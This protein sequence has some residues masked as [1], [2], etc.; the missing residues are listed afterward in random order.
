MGEEFSI[1]EARA[2]LENILGMEL[3]QSDAKL[4]S[5]IIRLLQDLKCDD[6]PTL[7][8]F[9]EFAPDCWRQ[10]FVESGKQILVVDDS[11][12]FSSLLRKILE[13]EGYSVI[14][15][16]TAKACLKVIKEE[17]FDLITMDIELPDR[18]GYSLCK[19]IS[20]CF[21]AYNENEIHNSQVPIVVVTVRDRIEDRMHGLESG[22]VDFLVK[23]DVKEKIGVLLDRI[24][25]RD[26]R[27][28][29]MSAIIVEENIIRRKPIVASLLAKGI[30]VTEFDDSITAKE[31]IDENPDK[32]DL[33]ILFSEI[34][35]PTAVELC[36][37]IKNQKHLHSLPVILIGGEEDKSLLIDFF[38]H[39]GN[40]Y[41]PS[42]FIKE[43]LEARLFD[44]L[45]TRFR[46]KRI[47][48]LI[49]KNLSM[50]NKNE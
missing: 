35:G 40:D 42:T 19:R 5:T 26:H 41:I 29:G 14:V 2:K 23:R 36:D 50:E 45:A 39:G 32:I 44:N 10:Y 31:Y 20:A 17:K 48:H 43:E 28:E 13:D 49:R 4:T 16:N 33:A 27:L 22:A 1:E 12:A 6:F 38:R 30:H 11:E 46:H 37:L 24:L 15:V 34:E 3:N 25:Q 9:I 8:V 47:V 7:C 18:N 21:S